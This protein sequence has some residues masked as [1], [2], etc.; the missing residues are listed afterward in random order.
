MPNDGDLVDLIPLF[1]PE[2]EFQGKILVKNPAR[3]FEFDRGS[4]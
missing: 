3:L 4:P 2:P 1:A